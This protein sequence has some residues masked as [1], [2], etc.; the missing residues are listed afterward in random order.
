[1]SSSGS[2]GQFFS[3]VSKKKARSCRVCFAPLKATTK[4]IYVPSRQNDSGCQARRQATNNKEQS[5]S[6]GTRSSYTSKYF[7][8]DKENRTIGRSGLNEAAQGKKAQK[9]SYGQPLLEWCNAF[10]MP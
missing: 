8:A 2:L 5:K 10:N 9:L 3:C 6:F 7:A 4:S 1:M